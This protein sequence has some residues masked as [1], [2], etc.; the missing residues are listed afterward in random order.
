MLQS[1]EPVQI[2]CRWS[3]KATTL[4]VKHYSVNDMRTDSMQSRARRVYDGASLVQ[5]SR[6][7][8]CMVSSWHS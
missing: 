7:S 8:A 6:W 3:L 2:A 1:R 5:A 4:S